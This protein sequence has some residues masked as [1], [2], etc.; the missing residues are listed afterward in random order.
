MHNHAKVSQC[1][2]VALTTDLLKKA[3]M[4]PK[5]TLKNADLSFNICCSVLVIMSC[6][7]STQRYSVFNEMTVLRHAMFMYTAKLYSVNY[8]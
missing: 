2:A 1:V 5:G 7:W 3:K 4:M 8:F 6:I